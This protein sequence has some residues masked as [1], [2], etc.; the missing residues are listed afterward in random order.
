MLGFSKNG[1]CSSAAPK[2]RFEPSLRID[3]RLHVTDTWANKIRNYRYCAKG[4]CPAGCV[5]PPLLVAGASSRNPGRGTFFEVLCRWALHWMALWICKDLLYKSWSQ[6]LS[7]FLCITFVSIPSEERR[8][9]YL[10]LQK[11]T[12]TLSQCEPGILII[13]Y[14]C[15]QFK[16]RRG[17]GA[18]AD[19]A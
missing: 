18:A 15:T 9:I 17:K 14:T 13:N 8:R 10:F 4:A 16:R 12:I 11:H 3:I 5:I 2:S 1:M 7:A 19:M 6:P